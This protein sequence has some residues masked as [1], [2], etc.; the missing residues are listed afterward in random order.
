MYFVLYNDSFSAKL[1][2]TKIISNLTDRLYRI[3]TKTEKNGINGIKKKRYITKYFSKTA[4][5]T[6]P[7]K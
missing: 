6:K 2:K 1:A 3:N 7:Y 5:N 4:I